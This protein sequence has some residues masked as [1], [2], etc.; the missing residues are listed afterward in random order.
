VPVDVKDVEDKDLFKA[1]ADKVDTEEEDLC[2]VG[3]ASSE[4]DL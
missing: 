4:N 3:Q 1:G 2:T